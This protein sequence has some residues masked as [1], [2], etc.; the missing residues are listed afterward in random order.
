MLELFVCAQ[1]PLTGTIS[2]G[3]YF[4]HR[5]NYIHA[6]GITYQLV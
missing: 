6:P 4:G 2:D 5:L 1:L 3:F